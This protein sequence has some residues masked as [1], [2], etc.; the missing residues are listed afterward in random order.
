MSTGCGCRSGEGTA[1]VA[2]NDDPLPD[3]QVR[4]AASEYDFLT[5]QGMPM[6]DDLA[7][8]QRAADGDAADADGSTSAADASADAEDYAFAVDVDGTSS[9][10]EASSTAGDTAAADHASAGEQPDEGGEAQAPEKASKHIALA[11]YGLTRSLEYTLE[12]IETQ[13][14]APLTA[15]GHTYDVYLH[16]YDV[17]EIDNPRDKFEGHTEVNASEWQLL[18]P[19]AHS[20]THQVC[21]RAGSV[22]GAGT[23]VAAA[24]VQHAL[25]V[26][27]L[28]LCP[29][30]GSEQPQQMKVHQAVS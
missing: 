7:D 13:I 28:L 11:F 6:S 12:S 4:R 8:Q 17:T 25:G 27:S 21:L 2:P 5:P 29:L 3:L 22:A 30:A 18:R 1:P 19:R 16:T 23:H 14:F 15:A 24:A 9:E 10:D 20:I 26:G